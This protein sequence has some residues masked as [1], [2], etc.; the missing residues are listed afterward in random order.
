MV[1]TLLSAVCAMGP[2]CPVIDHYARELGLQRVDHRRNPIERRQVRGWHDRR[3]HHFQTRL[4]PR[5][6]LHDTVIGRFITVSPVHPG[7]L[8]I[9]AQK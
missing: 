8:G 3:G 1:S 7:G 5:Q 6:R 2:L 4:V 9:E